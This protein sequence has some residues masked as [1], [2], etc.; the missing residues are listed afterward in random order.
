[1]AP[2]ISVATVSSMPGLLVQNVDR[3]EQGG[4]RRGVVAAQRLQLAVDA[5]KLRAQHRVVGR[6]GRRADALEQRQR[7]GE[8]ALDVECAGLG[9]A[10]VSEQRRVAQREGV[11]L[12]WLEPFAQPARGDVE[13][14]LGQPQPQLHPMA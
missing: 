9:Q 6:F 11:A 4:H 2:S 13:R 5:R 1:M 3:L 14:H 12:G 8:A 7:L 10:Y